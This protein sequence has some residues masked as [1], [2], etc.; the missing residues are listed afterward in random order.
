MIVHARFLHRDWTRLETARARECNRIRK[1]V[2]TGNWLAQRDEQY[3]RG[4][5]RAFGHF[6]KFLQPVRSERTVC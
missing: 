2:Q 4:R 5:G 1:K 3:R 6:V